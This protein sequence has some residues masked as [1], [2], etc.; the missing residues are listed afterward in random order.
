[1]LVWVATMDECQVGI[2]SDVEIKENNLMDVWDG[3]KDAEELLVVW[4]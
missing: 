2:K 1:M 3:Y 4:G